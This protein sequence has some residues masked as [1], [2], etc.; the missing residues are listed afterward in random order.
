[1]ADEISSFQASISTSQSI[2]SSQTTTSS[3]GKKQLII[4]DD[5]R[6]RQRVHHKELSICGLKKSIPKKVITMKKNIV[7]P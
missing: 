6:Q 2:Q 1:M 7:H 5:E 4:S 3:K